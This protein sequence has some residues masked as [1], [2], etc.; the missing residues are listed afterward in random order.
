[1][2]AR[3]ANGQ[4]TLLEDRIVIER[5]VGGLFFKSKREKT[6]LLKD[7]VAIEF[8]PAKRWRKYYGFIRF[9][10]KGG[11]ETKSQRFSDIKKDPH[12]IVFTYREAPTFEKMK[13]TIEERM[14]SIQES[15]AKPSNLDE[16]EKLA[17]LRDK[18]IITEEEFEAKKRQLLGL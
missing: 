8:S 9:T 10:F 3:G 6:I 13:E 15:G 11:Q 1:M 7:L 12:A 16:L 18:G 5:A 2:E 4:L 17:A 14:T